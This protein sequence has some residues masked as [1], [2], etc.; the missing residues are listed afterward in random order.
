MIGEG[1]I[2]LGAAVLLAGILARHPVPV[3][4]GA[5][6]LLAALSSRLWDRYGFHRLEYRRRFS[7]RRAF[8]GEPITFA[9]EVTNRKALPLAWLEVHDEIPQA[10]RPVRSRTLPSPRQR[11]KILV[12]MFSLRWYER[13]RRKHVLRCTARGDFQLGPARLRTGDVFGFHTQAREVP[14]TDRLIVYP[15][16]V[17][18]RDLGLPAEHPFGDARRRRPLFEDPLRVIGVRD[19]QPGDPMRRVHWKATAHNGRLQAKLYEFATTRPLALFCDVDTLG[20]YAHYRGYIPDLLETTIVVAASV[21]AWAYGQGHPVGMYANGFTPQARS[22]VAL[23]P[24]A[25]PAQLA[26]I[27]EALAKLLPT[28]MLPADA[29]LAE[30]ARRLPYGATAVLITSTPDQ[31]KDVALGDLARRGFGIAAVLVGRRAA[32]YAPRHVDVV[33]RVADDRW[34]RIDELP[35]A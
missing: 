11:R 24:D 7:P 6:V 27:L 12:D 33:H 16:V 21:A 29:L 8:V 25:G 2:A 1:W 19:Y 20:E 35:P 34:D 13:V 17:P 5:V 22:W 28:P 14:S 26:R 4:L 18:L 10:L 30:E 31:A 15:R 23:P 32:R 3:T 9:M